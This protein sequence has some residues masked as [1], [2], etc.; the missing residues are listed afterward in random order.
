MA[1]KERREGLPLGFFH[2]QSDDTL[3]KLRAKKAS[4]EE[5]SRVPFR[6]VEFEMPIRYLSGG[7]KYAGIPIA[8][9]ETEAP[10]QGGSRDL[11]R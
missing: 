8:K 6:S 7:V 10:S 4:G 9:E 2:N 3:L 5:K 1:E 11:E